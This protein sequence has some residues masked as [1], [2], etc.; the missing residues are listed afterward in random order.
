MYQFSYGEIIEEAA[1]S[2]RVRE[3]GAM[4]RAIALL[5]EAEDEGLRSVRGVE[6]L[7]FTRR[8]WTI[9]LEDLARSDNDLPR[10]LRANLISIGLWIMK[11]AERV[12]NGETDSVRTLIEIMS[13][14]RDGLK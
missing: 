11:E 6:A 4:D 1:T 2:S 3:R 13:I 12:R 14:I 7:L 5:E 8:L 9:M 10:E